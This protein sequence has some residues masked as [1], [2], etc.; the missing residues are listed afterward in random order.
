MLV[1]QDVIRPRSPNSGDQAG[2]VL[3]LFFALTSTSG[4]WPVAEIQKWLREAKLAV[5][6]PIWLRSV[7][8]A[9]QVVGVR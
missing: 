2:Q 8:G 5:R 9:A 7:P 3:N 4:T 6:R 1:I